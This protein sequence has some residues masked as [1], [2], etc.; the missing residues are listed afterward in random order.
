MSCC[1][2]SG[3]ALAAT[4][5]ALA[6]F[7]H[8][9]AHRNMHWDLKQAATAREHLQLL[10]NGQRAL[11]DPFFEDWELVNWDAL[12]HSVIHNDGNDYNVLVDGDGT[13]VVSLLDFGDMVHSATVVQPGGGAGLR[14]A[15]P[16]G[17]HC[18]GGAG[19]G[20]VLRDSRRWRRRRWMSLFTLA[21]TR[22]AMSVCY[23]AWQA[24]ERPENEYL[25]ISNRPAWAL[26]EKL[27][28]VSVGLGHGGVAAGLPDDARADGGGTGEIAA[29]APGSI[30]EYLVPAAAAYRARAGGS[31]CTTRAGGGT[32]IAST[33]WRTSGTAIRGWW[34]RRPGRWRG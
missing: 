20:G 12:P 29:A 27:S 1:G 25:N 32:W 18:S 2:R 17:S 30:A 15:G 28:V 11:V 16:A 19:G 31:T 23:C 4:D 24:G 26:L 5:M 33:T 34:L 6:G 10:T 13:R 9:A 21:A 7:D 14:D 8:P 22:L 3:R